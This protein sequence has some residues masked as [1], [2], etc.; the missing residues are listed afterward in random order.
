M[1]TTPKGRPPMGRT[2]NLPRIKPASHA[3]LVRLAET[4]ETSVAGMIEKL[5]EVKR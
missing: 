1:K 2:A 4:N 3:K 5:I